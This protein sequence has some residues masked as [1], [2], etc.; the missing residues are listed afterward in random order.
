MSI[1]Q[2]GTV[3]VTAMS[4]EWIEGSFTFVA[5]SI[6]NPTGHVVISAESLK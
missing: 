4:G 1:T 6:N 5:H 2:S 3:Q